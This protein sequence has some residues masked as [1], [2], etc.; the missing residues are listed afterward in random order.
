MEREVKNTFMK[1]CHTHQVMSLEH[2][3]ACSGEQK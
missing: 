3:L 2:R 1:M